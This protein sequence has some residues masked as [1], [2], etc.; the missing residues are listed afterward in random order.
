MFN[1]SPLFN[2]GSMKNTNQETKVE[3]NQIFSRQDIVER[4]QPS[5]EAFRQQYGAINLKQEKHNQSAQ[6]LSQTQTLIIDWLTAAEIDKPMA[7]V[8]PVIIEAV[9]ANHPRL[10]NYG[11]I[12][13]EGC[14]LVLLN[15]L[16]PN[17][18]HLACQNGNYQQVH[19]LVAAGYPVNCKDSDGYYPLHR[20]MEYSGPQ[21]EHILKLLVHPKAMR[22]E[23][24]KKSSK[25]TKQINGSPE[26][27]LAIYGRSPMHTA[28]LFNN[29]VGAQWLIEHFFEIATRFKQTAIAPDILKQ[30][31]K[32][33]FSHESEKLIS[34]LINHR[35]TGRFQG[36]TPLHNAVDHGQVEMVK[37]LTG[38]F[39][40]AAST[41]K[42]LKHW[43]HLLDRTLVNKSGMTA[44]GGIFSCQTIPE[45]RVVDVILALLDGGCT[46]SFSERMKLKPEEHMLKE[47]NSR[48][49]STRLDLYDRLSHWRIQH[50]ALAMKFVSKLESILDANSTEFHIWYKQLALVSEWVLHGP[51]N[52]T[53]PWEVQGAIV[54][55]QVIA[56]QQSE[57]ATRITAY[58]Q[59]AIEY[60]TD[61]N[62]LSGEAWE[63][64]VALLN[65]WQ[66][67]KK[68]SNSLSWNACGLVTYCWVLQEKCPKIAPTIE[69]LIR[70]IVEA[71]FKEEYL[72]DW[73]AQ[74]ADLQLL[75]DGKGSAVSIWQA[76]EAI[77][78]CQ[79]LRL[80]SPNVSRRLAD[81]LDPI[82]EAIVNTAR[83]PDRDWY[84]YANYLIE[85]LEQSKQIPTIPMSLPPVKKAIA[86]FQHILAN[87]TCSK[88]V[89]WKITLL[90]DEVQ[91]QQDMFQF[92][93]IDSSFPAVTFFQSVCK[94]QSSINAISF[95]QPPPDKP[96][97][98][99]Y[100]VLESW[101][102]MNK[103]SI[104]A[105]SNLK[106]SSIPL[107]DTITKYGLI[108]T[109]SMEDEGYFF[110]AVWMQLPRPLKNIYP[111]SQVLRA[112]VAEHIKSHINS[113]K[114]FFHDALDNELKFLQ[115]IQMCRAN[116]DPVILRATSR[117]LN[118]TLVVITDWQEKTPNI[119]RQQSDIQILLG[120]DNIACY[121]VLQPDSRL[122]Q[123]FDIQEC[124]E[125]KPLDQGIVKKTESDISL[126]LLSPS[127]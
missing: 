33:F 20:A 59:L 46:L 81:F 13:R 73:E 70:P 117:L 40:T 15:L 118:A 75:S 92:A 113:Y 85:W 122:E 94:D 48:V 4:L 37:F 115:K 7:G 55:L 88:S 78:L 17:C 99:I 62:I 87:D 52:H 43:A 22:L 58:F 74:F 76:R 36:Y 19:G 69:I 102:Q 124:I 16:P 127:S 25:L 3:I 82:V 111:S 24:V 64:T 42:S 100:T 57:E 71:F 104:P 119:V 41:E 106:V 29:I 80:K 9:K 39:S 107:A 2:L 72:S 51:K 97:F 84:D 10:V 110:D 66:A 105:L 26:T 93:P 98:N 79:I 5:Y 56:S 86:Y 38:T 120:R 44:L 8:P 77:L 112:G 50:N 114:V 67:A 83:D 61:Y 109:T 126:K 63:Q 49:I 123:L 18:L 27:F 34:W 68:V 65:C 47:E 28:A 12:R 103:N 30:L 31:P 116:A 53:A 121:H 1:H 108:C 14:G 11:N 21:L 54:Y 95:F 101:E 35:E 32:D 125:N 89:A 6:S 96:S 91:H 45:N 90:L 60:I 23:K